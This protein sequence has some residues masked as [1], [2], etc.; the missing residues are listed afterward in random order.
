MH[1][2]ERA[3][4]EVAHSSPFGC[5]LLPVGYHLFR[6]A[7]NFG[8]ALLGSQ[9]ACEW[10]RLT[11]CVHIAGVRVELRNQQGSHPAHHPLFAGART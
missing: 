10:I 3:G 4:A 6:K 8:A 1:K 5:G 7:P 2:V 11:C 9:A